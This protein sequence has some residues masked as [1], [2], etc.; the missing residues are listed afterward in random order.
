MLKAQNLADVPDKA[1][2]RSNLGIATTEFYDG[3][4]LVKGSNL[5]D[6]PNKASARQNIDVYSRGGGLHKAASRNAF[7]LLD[8]FLTLQPLQAPPGWIIADGRA[9]SQ[10]QYP[11]LFALFGYVLGRYRNNLQYP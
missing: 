3:R 11:R 4:Y 9:L 8:S 7:S 10:A 6:V 2:A 5:A 1:V